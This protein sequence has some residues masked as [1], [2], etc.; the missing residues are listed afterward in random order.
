MVTEEMI[1]LVVVPVLLL[2]LTVIAVAVRIAKAIERKSLATL[3]GAVGKSPEQLLGA[4]GALHQQQ[5]PGVPLARRDLRRGVLWLSAAI[6]VAVFSFC[7]MSWSDPAKN[8]VLALGVGAFPAAM[9]IG[10]LILGL[11]T[12]RTQS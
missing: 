1:Q 10:Y 2:C 8:S 11:T 3:I 5:T 9:G 12:A 4:L 6:G 7:V